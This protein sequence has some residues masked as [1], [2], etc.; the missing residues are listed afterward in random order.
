MA[1]WKP[2]QPDEAF[3]RIDR[4]E[5]ALITNHGY[6]GAEIP[7]GGAPDTGGQNYY[8]NT[9]AAK[10]EAL[11]Y[12]VT[13]FARGG[14]PFFDSDRVR[15]GSEYMSD[16]LRY[17]YVPGGGDRFVR[18]ESIAVALD[19]QLDWLASFCRI[20]ADAQ[21]R[22]PWDLYEFIN[23]HYWDAAVL[24]V[25]LVERW[26]N[27][28][29]ESS[30]RRMLEGVVSDAVFAEVHKGL[31]WRALGEVPDFYLGRMLMYHVGLRDHPI[32]HQVRAAATL[33]ASARAL[34]AATEN[35]LVDRVMEHLARKDIHLDPRYEK[36]SA[37]AALGREI[38]AGMPEADE[39]LKRELARVDRHVWTPHSI[40]ELKDFN[41]RDRPP[42]VR[43]KLKLSERRSHERMVCQRTHAFAA[44]SA[45]IAERLWTHYRVPVEDTFYF[46]P[47]VDRDVFR[48]YTL[49]EKQPGYRWLAET[50]GLPRETLEQST[51]VFETSRMD[52]TKR[53]DLL[54]AAFARIAAK[55]PTAYLLIGG[56]PASDVFTGLRDQLAYTDALEGRAFLL[57]TIPDEHIGAM[58][59]IAD[60]YATAS[61]MEGFGMSVSQAASAATAVVSTNT[62]PF[63]IHHAAE[64][65]LLFEP[66]DLE[67]LASALGR[68]IGDPEECERRGLAME[69]RLDGLDWLKRTRDFLGYLTRRGFEIREGNPTHDRR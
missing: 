59:S 3:R 51:L 67:G 52:R 37:A 66:G 2:D 55:H 43:R 11:G 9:L 20:E 30:L 28:A 14:F 41:Y 16:R 35:R 6:G 50:T 65:A 34:D 8:V 54:L 63:S 5:I 15:L 48:T 22:N 42:D 1:N 25:G 68:L 12:K 38:L 21:G 19:E 7:V 10:L 61:E 13:I 44:T 47:C 32:E 69:Q 4:P 58:F 33:W 45:Q 56:G 60:I 26:R 29:V 64:Q 24:G 40:G 23:S 46:P 36:L 53:K 17:V 57:G 31:R 62:I 49:E 18:K 27:L 39:Q